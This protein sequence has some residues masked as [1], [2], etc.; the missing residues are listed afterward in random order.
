MMAVIKLVAIDI[1]G[2]LADRNRQ[3]SAANRQAIERLKSKGVIVVLASGRIGWSVETFQKVVGLNGYPLVGTNGCEV[4]GW[5]RARVQEFWLSRTLKKT[6]LDIA[7]AA[8]I[9]VNGYAPRQLYFT[10]DGDFANLYRSR[11]EGANPQIVTSKD[12]LETNLLKL[13]FIA[14]PRVLDQIVADCSEA[15]SP[16]ESTMTRSEPEYLEF[17][18]AGT[19]KGSGLRLLCQSLGI[20]QNEVAAI[21]DYYNDLEM[22]EWS[23]ISA[24][25][26]N[27]P[28]DL[29]SIADV[30]VNDNDSDGVAEFLNQLEA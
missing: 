21:G 28:S 3:V 22:L 2:T 23:G 11:V 1:D 10:Q 14:N 25:M 6:A 18:P 29:Q 5:D 26:G 24:A 7:E 27:A 12:L 19:S 20:Q 16:L 30:V 9:H 17:L 4:I 8:G 13:L 15:F